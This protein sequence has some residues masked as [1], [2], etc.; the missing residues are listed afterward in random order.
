MI[1]A[2]PPPAFAHPLASPWW[3]GTD[4]ITDVAG[5]EVGQFTDERRPTGCSVVLARG[6][7]VA[8]VDVR[9][10]RTRHA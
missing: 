4:A 5:I 1:N 2:A 10:A 7:A 8:G 9:G 6:G 3:A